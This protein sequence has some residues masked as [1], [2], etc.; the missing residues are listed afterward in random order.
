MSL[1]HALIST[2]GVC[3]AIFLVW[4]PQAL[5]SGFGPKAERNRTVMRFCGVVILGATTIEGL[6]A[7][8]ARG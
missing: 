4:M 2:F 1:L 3:W 7:L 6:S 5:V 8:L